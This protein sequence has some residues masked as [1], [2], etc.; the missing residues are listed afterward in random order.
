MRGAAITGWSII[1]TFLGVFGAWSIFAPLNGAVV[2]NGVVK[3]EGNRK[4]IQHLDGGIV[5]QLF[6]NEGDVVKAGDVLIVLDDTQAKAEFDVLAQMYLG[7]RV[8][9]ERL[10]AEFGRLNEL[11][12]PADLSQFS[13][14]ANT[15][16][17]WNGQVHLFETRRAAIE[18]QRRIINEKIAQ[19]ESQIED[20]QAQLLAYESQ[21]QSVLAELQSIKGLVDQGLIARPRYLQLERNGISLEGQSADIRANI[22]KLRQGI[23]EQQQQ[24]IQLENDRATEIVRDL[25][26]TQ[27]KVLDVLPRTMN[28][29]A[30]LARMDIRSSYSGKIV[31]LNDFSVGAVI[32][33][34]DKILDIVPDEKS[35]V[36]EAQVAVD[37]ISLVHPGMATE[38][39]LTAYKQRITP[40]VRGEV[41]QVSADRLVEQR[42]GNAYYTAQVQVNGADLQALP[43]VQLYP[44]MSAIVMVPTVERT[45]F[46]YFVGPLPMTF[47]QSFRQL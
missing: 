9:E 15:N 32:N 20:G 3:T 4:S 28:A 29:K 5:K 24:I 38:I 2:A 42:T 19:I 34:S 45:A 25:R 11:T 44:G 37:D 43:N 27:A 12:M 47:K 8:T 18:G 14:D 10:R 31:A 13:D 6:V 33:R 17:I 16:A 1:I 41:M 46:D 21:H 22:A 40:V 7:T 23:S 35:L 36:I 39:H 26:D 30:S